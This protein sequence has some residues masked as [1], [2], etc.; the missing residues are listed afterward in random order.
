MTTRSLR[1]ISY[2]IKYGIQ[3]RRGLK[4]HDQEVMV[5]FYCGSLMQVHLSS[6]IILELN[7]TI[8]SHVSYHIP[9]THPV[10]GEDVT[11]IVVVHQSGQYSPMNITI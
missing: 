3:V 4:S 6:S 11:N 7:Q 5:S 10:D 9:S 1:S 2:I 8:G